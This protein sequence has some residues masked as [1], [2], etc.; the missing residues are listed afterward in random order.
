MATIIKL[1]NK[2]LKLKKYWIHGK[3]THG[4]QLSSPFLKFNNVSHG[5]VFSVEI[6]TRVLPLP[7]SFVF[8][9]PP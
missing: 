5:L 2:K 7:F 4:V 6:K 1:E 3:E 9:K 8:P